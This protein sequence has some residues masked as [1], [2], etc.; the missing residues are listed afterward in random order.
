MN[1][2]AYSDEGKSM[3]L[4]GRLPL[5]LKLRAAGEVP[6][7]IPLPIGASVDVRKVFWVPIEPSVHVGKRQKKLP[8]VSGSFRMW[9]ALLYL[10]QASCII[11]REPVSFAENHGVV[12]L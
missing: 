7:A 5:I 2:A 8:N 10:Q 12:G 1:V 9:G 6:K 3:E 4:L 11:N